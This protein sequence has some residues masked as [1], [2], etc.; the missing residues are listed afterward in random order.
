[1]HEGFSVHFAGVRGNAV[2]L[3]QHF[4]AEVLRK[5]SVAV[6][7]TAGN[8][9]DTLFL[10]NIVGDSGKVYAFDIQPEALNTTASRLNQ[11]GL[12]KNVNLINDGHQ[13]MDHYLTS[14]VDCFIF[15]LG[16]LP[17]GD[18]SKMTRSETTLEALNIAVNL[19]KPGG[20]ISIVVYT[21]HHGAGKE[22]QCVEEMAAQLD[23]KVFGVLKVTFANRSTSAPFLIFIER[24]KIPD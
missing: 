13:N 18:H 2:L 1:M 5:G 12:D 23:P 16:Y 22:S 4:I 19:L 10:A 9:Y 24:V 6:D 20:R 3:A 14:P 11:F 8:G 7:G 21:S 15:N 17:G